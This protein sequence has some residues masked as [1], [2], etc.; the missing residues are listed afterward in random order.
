LEFKKYKGG[1]ASDAMMFI[2]G[3]M[4]ICPLVQKVLGWKI[5]GGIIRYF[6]LK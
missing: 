3:F 1:M 2:R 4:K 6:L 5:H